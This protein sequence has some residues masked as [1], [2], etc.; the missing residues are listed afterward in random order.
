MGGVDD[1]VAALE[2]M[3]AHVPLVQAMMPLEAL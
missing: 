2:K 3:L 1:R